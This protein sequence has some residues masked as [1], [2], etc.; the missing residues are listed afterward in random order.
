MAGHEEGAP[1]P[2]RPPGSAGGSDRG[3]VP[4]PW[5]RRASAPCTPPGRVALGPP[6][7]AS[8]GLGRLR[9]TVCGTKPPRPR[10]G[11]GR[12]G[13]HHAES[14]LPSPALRGA[15]PLPAPWPA[16][17]VTAAIPAPVV[18]GEGR[19]S[20][21]TCGGPL[22]HPRLAWLGGL[23]APKA[24]A[25]LVPRLD[26]PSCPRRRAR[27]RRPCEK[28]SPWCGVRAPA[29][30]RDRSHHAPRAG[31]RIVCAQRVM[32]DRQ[33]P[34]KGLLPQGMLA[35]ERA[36]A[37]SSRVSPTTLKIKAPYKSWHYQISSN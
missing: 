28:V 36:W 14:V 16:E 18:Q 19:A 35:D 27:V 5:P 11:A 13:A 6:P 37:L 24:P 21:C 29:H 4:G 15:P 26:P 31:D 1:A 22:A 12:E 10:A 7:E 8:S 2:R 32:T 33:K 20:A 3:S 34:E 9:P 23:L 25:P 17:Q 30:V